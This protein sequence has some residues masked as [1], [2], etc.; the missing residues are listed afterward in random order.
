MSVVDNSFS[1]RK[2]CQFEGLKI[3]LCRGWSVVG[4]GKL[5]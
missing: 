2:K 4:K 5:S 3:L 1:L